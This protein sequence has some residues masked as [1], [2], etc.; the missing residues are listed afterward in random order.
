MLWKM[1]VGPPWII[2]IG[3]LPFLFFK[4][5]WSKHL[6][7]L[8]SLKK[9][10]FKSYYS[11]RCCYNWWPSWSNSSWRPPV[12]FE[13]WWFYWSGIQKTAKAF[14]TGWKNAGRRKNKSYTGLVFLFV[15]AFLDYCSKYTRKRLRFLPT[16]K[17]RA[18]FITQVLRMTWFF[19]TLNCF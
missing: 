4:H 14:T 18:L 2:S 13:W 1:E 15:A 7:Y 8:F 17:V 12:K 11:Y 10:H 5:Y 9:F 19:T 16:Y 6:F 3:F